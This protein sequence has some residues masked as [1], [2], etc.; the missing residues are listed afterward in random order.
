MKKMKVILSVLLILVLS[1]LFVACGEDKTPDEGSTETPVGLTQEEK[2][3]AINELKEFVNGINASEY[4]IDNWNNIQSL[5]L[6]A[7][8]NIMSAQSK[9]EMNNYVSTFKSTVALVQK[10]PIEELKEPQ[11]VSEEVW[12]YIISDLEKASQTKDYAF[13]YDSQLPSIGGA[14]SDII[15]SLNMKFNGVIL[16]SEKEYYV[17]LESTSEFKVWVKTDETTKLS[18]VYFDVT[19]EDLNGKYYIGYEEIKDYIEGELDMLPGLDD[20][21]PG[22]NIKDIIPDLNSSLLPI[23]YEGN[24]K[25]TGFNDL[26]GTDIDGIIGKIIDLLKE[27]SES[28]MWI[29]AD[30]TTVNVH[31]DKDKVAESKPELKD[32]LGT[33]LDIT[34]TLANNNINKMIIKPVKNETE[35]GDGADNENDFLS[36]IDRV[37]IL[38]VDQKVSS[39]YAYTKILNSDASVGIKFDYVNTIIPSFNKD[40]F[41]SFNYQEYKN[42]KDFKKAALE[43]LDLYALYLL[44]VSETTF[45]EFVSKH[46]TDDLIMYLINHKE[47]KLYVGK[48]LVGF[49]PIY[50]AGCGDY[51]CRY[52]VT[53]T[54]SKVEFEENLSVIDSLEVIKFDIIKVIEYR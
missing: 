5:L 23:S 8:I 25:K 3:N 52:I 36:M 21:I 42:K 31:I 15:G 41:E 38:F 26:F 6:N 35:D 19:S 53:L 39:V 20:L 9:N 34:I 37:Q 13:K 46:A 24:V 51:L 12:G 17:N 18:T 44:D 50:Y 7:T 33:D 4:S 10:K 22:F 14:S 43:L 29:D 27:S 11:E 28:K 1:F 40:E 16:Q 48:A 30:V 54:G 45:E 32:Y 47:F 2:E 49:V